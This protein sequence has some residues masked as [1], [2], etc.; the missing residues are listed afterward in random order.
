MKKIKLLR[1][2]LS[3][4]IICFVISGKAQDATKL[5]FTTSVGLLNPVSTFSNSYKKSLH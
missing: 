4:T 3:L 5:F 1:I 2:C